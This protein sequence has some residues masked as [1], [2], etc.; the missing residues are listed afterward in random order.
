MIYLFDKSKN[1]IG[2]IKQRHTINAIFEREVN[3]LY[4]LSV[5]LPVKFRDKEGSFD[6]YAKID[7]ASYIGHYDLEDKFQMHRLINVDVENDEI[8]IDAIH[9]FFDEAKAYGVVAEQKYL[10]REISYIAPN[11]FGQIGWTLKDY[12]PSPTGNVSLYDVSLLEA[13]TLLLETYGFEMDVWLDFDGIKVTSKNYSLKKRIGKTTTKRYTYGTNVLSIKSEEDFGEIYTAVIGLG[14]DQDA[15]DARIAAAKYEADREAVRKERDRLTAE[16]KK[17]RSS[18]DAARKAVIAKY[19]ADVAAWRTERARLLELRKQKKKVTIPKKPAYPKAAP[20]PKAPT[21]PAYP[22]KPKEPVVKTV[23]EQTRE[24]MKRRVNYSKVVW[25][26]PSKPLNKAAGSRVLVDPVTTEAFGYR[27][28]QGVATPKVKVVIFEDIEDP[29]ELIQKSYEWLQENSRPK[30]LFTAEVVDGDT[31]VELGDT[32]TVIYRDIDKVVPIRVAKTTDDLLVKKRK[33]EFGDLEHVKENDKMKEFVAEL[34]SVK[35]N[36]KDALYKRKLEFDTM[37][38]D[39]EESL[40]TD[41]E[42]ALEQAQ[43][44]VDAFAEEM[45]TTI[46]TAQ[47]DFMESVEVSLVRAQEDAEERA[48]A[49]E[50]ALR[51]EISA[52]KTALSTDIANSYT[53]AVTD[54]EAKAKALD[55][56]ITQTVTANKQAADK[57][58]GE[59]NVALGSTNSKVGT[60]EQNVTAAQQNIATLNN[61][62]STQQEAINQAKQHIGGLTATVGQHTSSISNL[63]NQVKLTAS[64]TEVTDAINGIEIG[65]VNLIRNSKKWVDAGTDNITIGG[66]PYRWI[67]YSWGNNYNVTDV[68]K[69]G[70][71]YTISV[72]AANTTTSTAKSYI[73]IQRK[74]SDGTSAIAKYIYTDFAAE[75]NKKIVSTF[76]DDFEKEGTTTIYLLTTN[77]SANLYYSYPQLENGTKATPYDISPLDRDAL[78]TQNSSAII[79]AN[80][81]IT[82][83]V[84]K[85]EFNTKTGQIEQ[86]ANTAKTTADS[87]TQTIATV[88]GNVDA[89]SQWKADKGTAIEQTIN[90]VTNKAWMNDL[91]PITQ[92]VTT[93]EASIT[94]N[95]NEI[96][97]RVTKTEFDSTTGRIEGVANTAKSTAASNTQ[98]ITTVSGRVGT[99]E[100][101]RTDKGSQIDQTINAVSTKVWQSDIDAV[102]LGTRNWFVNSTAQLNKVMVWTT[103]ALNPESYSVVSDFIP[104]QANEKF[105]CNYSTS[106]LMYFDANNQFLDI[107]GAKSGGNVFT[108]HN[109]SRIK[110]IKISFRNNFLSAGTLA[111]KKVMLVKGTKIGQWL[112]AP[113]DAE[114][115]MTEIQSTADAVKIQADAIGKDYVKQSAVIV[116]SDGVLIGSKKVSGAEMASAISVTPSNVDII[117]K[118]MRITGDM[119]VAGD[120]KSLSLQAVNADIANLRANIL[121]ADSVTATALKADTALMNKLFVNDLLTNKLVSQTVYS[122]SVKALSVSAVRADIAWLKSNVITAG[123]ITTDALAADAVTSAKLKVDQAFVDKLM[124]STIY[125]NAIK[126]KSLEAVNG[127][128]ANLK[129]K[130]ITTDVIKASN[131]ASDLAVVDKIFASDALISRLTSK[132]AFVRDINSIS[133]TANSVLI[134]SVKGELGKPNSGLSI[135]RP[136]GATWI[137]NGV[138]RNEMVVTGCFPRFTSSSESAGSPTDGAT[139]FPIAEWFVTTRTMLGSNN[140]RIDAL[141]FNHDYRYLVLPFAVRVSKVGVYVMVEEF[142]TPTG[143]TPFSAT[144]LFTTSSHGG[145]G[146]QY[147]GFVIDLGT[148][149]FKRR[150]FYLYM[151]PNREGSSSD[152]AYARFLPFKLNG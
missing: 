58:M 135:T 114:N 54:A 136:D 144:K 71:T 43:I 25:A 86:T 59:L 120:V 17:V 147:D 116:Q 63:D 88:K 48:V 40:K 79:V 74:P 14:A 24:D 45:N 113:E 65:G 47:E 67:N 12:D 30:A 77:G 94:T 124:A 60:I 100:K 150:Q 97:R 149:T 85:T 53:Q 141:Y 56:T 29:N 109:D 2:T 81:E 68:M 102:E 148:P 16:Y 22:K 32:V 99:L 111:D 44:D 50:Q 31:R 20:R 80:D 119:Q 61:T 78:I 145:G 134:N 105:L 84:T 118:A 3:G 108:I 57:T 146:T 122:D 107:G 126:T 101:W 10:N 27:D 72:M 129:S 64:K 121:T 90:S 76:I 46:D 35:R 87:N 110:Y 39:Q 103:G 23:T 92:R 127:D 96:A 104:T 131:I 38:A 69:K 93:A 140:A 98:A 83:R 106:Q 13:R 9:I 130:I 112:P 52:Q 66:M 75:E 51:G 89:L 143:V 6:Y 95:A 128:I 19:E 73:A 55:A 36:V 152:L 82:K 28:A 11:V 34:K 41:F 123:S 133:V 117:T 132:T 1:L 62:T 142:G 37:F 125:T 21:L 137:E 7:K 15:I 33:I 91:N 5:D 49:M 4:T 151:K 70:E 139:V 26:K 138:G 42:I 8:H 115:R 18:Y